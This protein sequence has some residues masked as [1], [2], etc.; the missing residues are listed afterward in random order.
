M[1]ASFSKM[2]SILAAGTTVI[3]HDT[4]VSRGKLAFCASTFGTVHAQVDGHRATWTFSVYNHPYTFVWQPSSISSF[5]QLFHGHRPRDASVFGS[6]YVDED[7]VPIFTVRRSQVLACVFTL[8]ADVVTHLEQ[9]LDTHTHSVL[10]YAA[11]YQSHHRERNTYA[12]L[13]QSVTCEN[14]VSNSLVGVPDI[15]WSSFVAF[16]D[17]AGQK[18]ARVQSSPHCRGRHA[19]TYR[20][21]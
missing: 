7:F 21:S 13:V 19:T 2:S 20:G 12:E 11:W 1:I 3:A 4:D 10:T 9:L 15:R 18:G 6:M 8:I 14:I 5:L 16:G 17:D